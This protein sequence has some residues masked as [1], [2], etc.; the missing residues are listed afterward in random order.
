M[1][2][3]ERGQDPF[4]PGRGLHRGHGLSVGRGGH[5]DPSALGQRGEL[6]PDSWVVEPGRRRMGLGDLAVRV[7]EHQ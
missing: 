5:L 6:W 1:G 2:R 7:L 4:G 3:L